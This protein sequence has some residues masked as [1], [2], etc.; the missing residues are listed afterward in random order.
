[1]RQLRQA[2]DLRFLLLGGGFSVVGDT[3]A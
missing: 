3:R 2:N 1:L